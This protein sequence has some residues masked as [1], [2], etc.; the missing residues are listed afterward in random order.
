[1]PGIVGVDNHST[2]ITGNYGPVTLFT[3]GASGLFRVS[4]YVVADAAVSLATLQVVINYTDDTGANTQNSGAA[5]SFAVNGADLSFSFTIRSTAAAIT[6]STTTV[7][8]PKYIIFA[9]VEAL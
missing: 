2:Q 7:N 5:I 3:P 9:R 1:V 4:G 6:Y 8:S